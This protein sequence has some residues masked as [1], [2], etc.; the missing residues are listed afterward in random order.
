[1]L[2]CPAQRM[3]PASRWEQTPRTLPFEVEV[4]KASDATIRTAESED[5]EHDASTEALQPAIAM[6]VPQTTDLVDTT[7]LH[8]PVVIMPRIDLLTLWR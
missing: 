8:E 1:M 7:I 6:R 4:E 2:R 3:W 5:S